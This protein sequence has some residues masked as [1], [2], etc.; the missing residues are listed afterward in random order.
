MTHFFK[1]LFVFFIVISTATAQEL[2]RTWQFESIKDSTGNE[3]FEIIESDTLNFK[4]GKFNYTLRSKDNLKANGDYL[5]QNN[6]LVQF[7]S[8]L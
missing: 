4:S 7:L 6:I 1:V 2:D 8:T 3:L 5:H